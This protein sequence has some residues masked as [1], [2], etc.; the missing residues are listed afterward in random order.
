MAAEIKNA[1]IK[2]TFLGIE[3]HGMTTAILGLAYGKGSEQSFGMHSL[4]YKHYGIA[5]IRRI[6]DVVGVDS[7]EQLKGQKIRAVA[8]H[9]QV[10]AIGN[11]LDDNW[12]NPVEDANKSEQSE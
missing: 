11:W 9:A 1:I 10:Q 3:D 12:F 2:S 7:W 6:L 4:V 8:E 5:Y